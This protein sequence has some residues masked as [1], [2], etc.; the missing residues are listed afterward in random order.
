MD[1]FACHWHLGN[2]Q[3]RR[4]IQQAWSWVRIHGHGQGHGQRTN[5]LEDTPKKGPSLD[6]DGDTT[7]VQPEFYAYILYTLLL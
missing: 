4:C 1:I 5:L 7:E 2:H 6:P 3:P